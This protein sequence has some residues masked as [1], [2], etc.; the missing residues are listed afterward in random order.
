MWLIPGNL[1]FYFLGYE[2]YFTGKMIK[3][4]KPFFNSIKFSLQ[5]MNGWG[6]GGFI[7][8]RFSKL[9]LGL[10][11]WIFRDFF[12]ILGFFKVKH[13]YIIRGVDKICTKYWDSSLF[14][15]A[16]FVH[17]ELKT[18][19]IGHTFHI[20]NRSTNTKTVPRSYH[21]KN[22]QIPPNFQRF[23]PAIANPNR[24]E[25]RISEKSS[26][27]VSKYGLFLKF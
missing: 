8:L 11:L 26:C 6:F 1:L 12:L 9:I 22:Q 4:R 25:G 16:V 27:W 10:W 24:L 13:Y 21:A 18:T 23:R 5:A 3:W 17:K 14:I 7:F 15:G 19:K 20:K 2:K